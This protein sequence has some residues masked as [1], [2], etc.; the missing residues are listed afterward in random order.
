MF[1]FESTLNVQECGENGMEGIDQGDFGLY[2][3]VWPVVS[4]VAVSGGGA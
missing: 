1:L 2:P 3:D 4:V